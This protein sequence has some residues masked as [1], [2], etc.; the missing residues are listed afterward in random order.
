MVKAQ[1]YI[2]QKYPQE[3]RK[4][5]TEIN[6]GQKKLTGSLNLH[7]FPDLELLLCPQNELTEIEVS[8]CPKL[9]AVDC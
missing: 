8:K 6:I 1:E 9:K 4:N 3:Q 5:I 7:D 2:N